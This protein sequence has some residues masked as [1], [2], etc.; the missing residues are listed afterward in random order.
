MAKDTSFPRTLQHPA[1][2]VPEAFLLAVIVG[3]AL[4]LLPVAHA[5][6]GGALLLL[7]IRFEA[8]ASCSA[9]GIH[10]KRGP[11]VGKDGRA[12]RQQAIPARAVQ[13]PQRL[14]RTVAT[15]ASQP[16]R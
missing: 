9:Q 11:A 10:V 14:C 15:P 2:L 8:P 1:R 5:D 16:R 3:T 7:I 13:P 12:G 4:S 6:E